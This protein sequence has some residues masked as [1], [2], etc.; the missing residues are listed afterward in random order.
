MICGSC[1]P[2]KKALYPKNT[3]VVFSFKF[4]KLL[5]TCTMRR[6]KFTETSKWKTLYL[7]KTFYSS[8]LTLTLVRKLVK[9]LKK[10]ALLLFLLPNRF[11]K[12][13][14]KSKLRRRTST[15]PQCLIT[16]REQRCFRSAVCSIVFSTKNSL[17]EYNQKTSMKSF[18]IQ[19]SSG[20]RTMSNY[21]I[22]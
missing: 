10:L 11:Y 21:Q 13:L 15:M 1:G 6:E 7:V 14:Y 2:N 17:S 18:L 20:V 12:V 22:I 16:M 19:I 3:L 9:P 4:V 8:W 5:I